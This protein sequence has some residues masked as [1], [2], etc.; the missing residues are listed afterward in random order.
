[1]FNDDFLH[2][3]GLNL[4]CFKDLNKI[5]KTIY[6]TKYRNGISFNLVYDM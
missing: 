3:Q 1:M 6:Y 5:Q 4:L 2:G